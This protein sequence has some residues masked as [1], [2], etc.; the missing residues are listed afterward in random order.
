MYYLHPRG[1]GEDP[2]I[3]V[4]GCGGTGGFV[5]EGLCR[6]FTGR[7]A[8]IVLVDHDRVEPHNLLRQN[9]ESADVGG[10]KSEVLAERLSRQ[11]NRTLGCWVHPFAALGGGRFPGIERFWGTLLIGCVD[12]AAAR[13][14]MALCVERNGAEWWID[15]GNGANWGQVLVGN[16]VRDPAVRVE[17]DVCYQLPAPTVQRPDLL[18]AVPDTPP[19]VDCA[20]ALDLTDQDPAINHLMASLVVTVVRRLVA[21]TCP[22]SGLYLDMERGTVTPRFPSPDPDDGQM[23]A[24]GEYDEPCC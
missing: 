11:F 14:E 8:T 18:T 1:L 21:G 15:A 2:W 10:F 16:M 9:F 13:R 17:G 4:V 7:Q 6:L 5:A 23:E 24:A 19:E 20:A 3:T 22:W 12:N